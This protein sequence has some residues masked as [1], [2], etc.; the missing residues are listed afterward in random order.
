MYMY[1]YICERASVERSRLYLEG[2][3]HVHDIL[4]ANR[5]E[6]MDGPASEILAVAPPRLTVDTS[7][8]PQGRAGPQRSHAS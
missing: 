2:P 5:M 8:Q 1:M 7:Q 3:V 6:P 4:I